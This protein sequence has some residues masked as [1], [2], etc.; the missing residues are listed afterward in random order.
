M[1][2]AKEYREAPAAAVGWDW[3]DEFFGASGVSG[4]SVMRYARAWRWIQ[5]FLQERHLDMT[6]VRY[7]HAAEYI[8]W[9]I[10]RE[11][12]TGKRSGRNTAV[13]EVKILAMVM[14]EGVR[15]GMIVASPLAGLKLRKD[16]AARKRV[17]T[18]SEI[19]ACRAALVHGPE[20]MRVS[21]DIALCT[22]CRLR[23]TRI[24]IDCLDL[25]A[26]IPTMTFPSPK[27]GRKKTF[28]IPVPA[29]L[30]GMFRAMVAEGRSHT[31][32]GF[33]FQPSRRWQQFFAGLKIEGVC[34]HCLRVTKVTLMRREG[35]PRE[36]AMRLVNHSSEMIHQ[37]YDRHR[38][39]D[40]CEYADAGIGG[41]C[42]S[43]QQSRSKIF[44]LP[45]RGK[46]GLPK[47]S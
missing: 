26:D 37:L 13:Q 24:P 30:L 16:E 31:I 43:K 19:A 42:A 21:F 38:V 47:M 2:E 20:W 12:K 33:P 45:T 35:V 7:G 14:A 23:E 28:S 17:F 34:F 40:L 10:G 5:M 32:D 18:D 36:V 1:A 9:R 46:M 22:G 4:E 15:R 6:Q 29:P 25:D 39:Q 27:G 11:R 3:V 8:A 41:F 44:S